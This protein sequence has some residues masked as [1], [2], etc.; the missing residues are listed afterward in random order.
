MKMVWMKMVLVKN[1]FWCMWFGMKVGFDD[2][3]MKGGNFDETV[4]NW[5]EGISQRSSS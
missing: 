2:F 4:L 5:V 1:G 3:L